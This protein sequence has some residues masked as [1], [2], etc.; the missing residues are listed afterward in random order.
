M[1][2]LNAIITILKTTNITI[3]LESF[4]QILLNLL[5]KTNLICFC[6]ISN[7]WEYNTRPRY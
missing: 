3:F 5:Q 1:L 6:L 2:N 4:K 7:T